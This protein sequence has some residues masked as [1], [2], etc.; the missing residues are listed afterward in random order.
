[1]PMLPQIE[2]A[3]KSAIIVAPMRGEVPSDTAYDDKY[4]CGR[5]YPRLCM[6]FPIS[7]IQKS[8]PRKNSVLSG[9]TL[10]DWDIGIRGRR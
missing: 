2:K 5:K 10:V 9:L 7:N 1:M 4:V 8:F 6:T 3:L